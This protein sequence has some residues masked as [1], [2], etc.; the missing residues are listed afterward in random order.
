MTGQRAGRSRAPPRIFSP[1]DFFRLKRMARSRRPE[2]EKDNPVAPEA[3][4]SRRR[5]PEGR[6][7][8]GAD[9]FKALKKLIDAAEQFVNRVPQVKRNAVAHQTLLDAITHAQ[10]VLSVRHVPSKF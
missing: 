1:A 7:D 9:V 2:L 5:R 6:S 10:L 3:Y 4:V 8:K